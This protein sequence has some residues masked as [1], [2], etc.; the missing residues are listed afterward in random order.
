MPSVTAVLGKLSDAFMDILQ[1]SVKD[2]LQAFYTAWNSFVDETR[3]QGRDKVSGRANPPRIGSAGVAQIFTFH[4]FDESKSF[5][6][7]LQ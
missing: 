2:R 3:R 1:L 6:T 4:L 5:N 7:D